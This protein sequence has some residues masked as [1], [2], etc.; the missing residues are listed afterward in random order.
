MDTSITA[1]TR[2][3]GTHEGTGGHGYDIYPT[4][5]A[6]VSYYPYS[7]VPIDIPTVEVSNTQP[8]ID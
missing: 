6:R 1:G 5:R 7:W 4:R 8:L 3:V 2:I